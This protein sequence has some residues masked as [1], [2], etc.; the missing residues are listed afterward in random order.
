VRCWGDDDGSQ[1]GY[2]ALTGYLGDDETPASLG[3]IHLGVGRTATAVAVG[4]LHTCVVLDHGEVAC[5]GTANFGELGYPNLAGD[6]GDDETPGSAGTVHLGAGRS[7][8]AI[9][10]GTFNTCAL[11]DNGRVRCWGYSSAGQL[12]YANTATIG[13]DETPGSAGPVEVRGRVSIAPDAVVP[14]AALTGSGRVTVAWT[15]PNPGSASPLDYRIT[16]RTLP[17]VVTS[18]TSAE[19]SNLRPGPYSFEV[20]AMN[21]VR[22]GPSAVTNTVF[23]FL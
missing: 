4:A 9:T 10:A 18:S 17:A 6:I 14:T 22:T 7:A 13:D 8:L 20:T 15:A 2:P 5:W 1:L 16:S 3:P 21:A 19:F 12:G 23:V 11:L